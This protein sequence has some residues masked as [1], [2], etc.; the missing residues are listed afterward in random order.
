VVCPCSVKTESEPA[1]AEGGGPSQRR[2]VSGWNSIR[3]DWDD[4]RARNPRAASRGLCMLIVVVL[5]TVASLIGT[6]LEKLERCV[7]YGE[8]VPHSACRRCAAVGKGLI[9][10][11]DTGTYAGFSPG[12]QSIHP[13]VAVNECVRLC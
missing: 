9:P 13:S 10:R 6:S 3:R 4:W 2:N 12:L 7:T 1:Q 5:V 11:H 8:S